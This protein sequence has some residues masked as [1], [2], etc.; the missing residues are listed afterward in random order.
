[1]ENV[2]MYDPGYVLRYNDIRKLE[3]LLTL[4]SISL[5]D[6]TQHTV[7]GEYKIKFRDVSNRLPTNSYRL[8]HLG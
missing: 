7:A 3:Y 8:L 2:I 6:S 5:V 1:M 4:D